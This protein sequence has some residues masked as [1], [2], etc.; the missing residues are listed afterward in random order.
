MAFVSII[1]RSTL[2]LDCISCWTSSGGS[3]DKLYENAFEAGVME[4]SGPRQLYER[5]CRWRDY[6]ITTN[7]TNF[8]CGIGAPCDA[9]QICSSAKPPDWYILVATQNWS[10]L[11]NDLY[12]SLAYGIGTVQDIAPSMVT[13]LCPERSALP[14]E[15]ATW[16]GLVAAFSG[17]LP[18]M[19]FPGMGVWIWVG[20][21]G[22]LYTTASEIWFYQNV[23]RAPPDVVSGYTKWTNFAWMLSTMQDQAQERIS[24]YTRNVLSAG[25]S[26]DDGMYGVL[27]NGIFLE[28]PLKR[29]QF[30]IQ[31][32]FENI[33]R[34]KLL[35]AIM[36]AQNIYITRGS[37]PCVHSGAG[38]AFDNKGV[39][40]YCGKD[41]VMMNIVQAKGSHTKMKIYGAELIES[42]YGFSTAFLT[43]AAWTCQ[44]KYGKY[45]YDPYQNR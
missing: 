21:Q 39:L 17:A 14:V 41:N 4:Q 15:S 13:D 28:R 1:G 38:G 22:V 35:G 7:M 45:E 44:T 25:I 6:A 18:G 27:K 5:I 10:Q 2:Q 11:M 16:L 9:G 34:L 42:K 26:S 23:I 33:V 3:T 12:T 37:D 8:V 36:R 32:S 19:I 43:K 20:L 30:E 40:S 29:P 24:N 31:T